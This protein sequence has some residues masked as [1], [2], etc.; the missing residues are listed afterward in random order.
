MGE[1]KG[2][3]TILTM[4]T[5]PPRECGIATFTRDLADSIDK[6]FSYIKTKKLA[7]NNNSMST[8][9]Y[10]EDVI[11]QIQEDDIHEYIDVAKRINANEE[12][13][14][15][16][17]QHEFGIFGGEYGSNLLAFL[18]VIN[19]PVV[20]TFHSVIPEPNDKLKKIVQALAEKA[21]CIVVMANLGKE[22]LRSIYNI[23]T[24]IEVIP[25]G[26]P[27]IPFVSSQ[28]EKEKIGYADRTLLMSFGMISS[29][30]GYEYVV[31]ALPK[32]VEK[33][34]NLL[35]LIV[36]ETHPVVRKREGEKYRNMI[37]KKIKKLG[38]QKNVRFYNKYVKLKEIIQYL[39]ASDICICSNNDPNQVTSGTLAYEVGAGRAVIST[40]FIHAKELITPENGVLAN[41]KDPN[42]FA[43]AILKILANPELKKEMERTAYETTRHMTWDNVAVAYTNT[44]NKCVNLTD[45]YGI[46]VPAINL[47]HLK[48]LTDDFGVIQFANNVVPDKSSG[49]TLDDNSRALI[50]SCMHYDSFKDAESLELA[51]KYLNFIKNACSDGKIYNYVNAD[52]KLSSEWSE[53]P[54]GRAIWALGK[55][56][57]SKNMPA[58]MKNTARKIF[59]KSIKTALT[60]KSP[61]AVSSV[62]IGLSLI[63]SK[64]HIKEMADYLVSLYNNCSS[65]DWQWFEEYLTYSNSKMSEALFYA[66]SVLKDKEY[67]KTAEDSLNFLSSITLQKGIFE[68]IGQDGWYI[69]NKQRAHFDQQPEDTASM[70][71]TLL[72]ANKVTDKKEYLENAVVVFQWFLGRNCL[73]RMIYDET[74]GGCHD[75]LGEHAINLNQ[76]AE[77]TI[78]YLMARL[79]LNEKKVEM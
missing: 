30:K 57:S 37:E 76:G 24:D 66:Y 6:N 42:S 50:V 59:D 64:K 79:D 5:Y 18:E 54:H 13:K 62:I 40:P 70:V 32:V 51:K 69:K 15:I 48:N 10:P 1:E 21:E 26:I 27:T 36:G 41:F 60:F 20:I 38:L 72:L 65:K 4:S 16:N 68:P 61:R 55:L 73:N 75:G 11:Y 28:K 77:S 52:K 29:G 39:K 46:T 43:E 53:D 45:K 74:T 25:H 58:N 71:Q 19:K 31:E 22:I 23:K 17:I 8:Y 35:Y 67:L 44:F 7:M 78:S 34:P 56:I 33:F 49:Y 12:I 2:V 9:N 47:A 3:S 14:L 63:S